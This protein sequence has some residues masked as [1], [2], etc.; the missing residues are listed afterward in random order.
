[1]SYAERTQV[2]YDKSIRDIVAMVKKAGA[3]KVGQMEEEDRVTIIFSLADR[4]IKFRVGWEKSPQS[5]RQRVRALLLVIK[6][7]LESVASGVETFEQAF[8]ANIVL[9]DGKTVH[10]RV[11]GDLALEYRNSK[12]TM[13]LIGGPQE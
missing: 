12:P 1:M 10:E 11:C 9:A 13:Y 2:P 5:Q 7:K 4:Q 3:L 6:A 8:L